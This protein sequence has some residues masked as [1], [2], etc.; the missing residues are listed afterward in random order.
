[1]AASMTDDNESVSW[2]LEEVALGKG[3]SFLKATTIYVD[4][5]THEFGIVYFAS[6]A[7]AVME[8]FPETNEPVYFTAKDALAA[9]WHTKCKKISIL[10]QH[11]QINLGFY[12]PAEARGFLDAFEDATAATQNISF[13]TYEHHS[14]IKFREKDFDMVKEKIAGRIVQPWMDAHAPSS[15]WPSLRKTGEW[16]DFT[17]IA[18]DRSFA[19]HRVKLCKESDYFKA[20]C[21]NGFA[22][23]NELSVKLPEQERIVDVLLD[24]M[25]GT[26][27][28]TTGSIFTGFALRSEMEKERVLNDLLDVFITADK[29]SLEKIKTKVAKAIIDRMPFVHDVLVI[30]DLAICIFDEQCP[31][32]DRGLRKAILSQLRDRM[33]LILKDSAAW[34]EYSRSKDVLMAFHSH[35]FD[36]TI[37]DAA[38]RSDHC[39]SPPATLMSGKRRRIS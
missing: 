28:S 38:A 22:E 16:S 4:R 6:N 30:V 35:V 39:L 7:A 37:P 18:G 20:I 5:A 12:S 10:F 3:L 1:M 32:V 31:Q 11:V 25:Y 17:I 15:E 29:Y 34:Q 24:E 21:G 8:Q 26:Y 9:C 27:N 19:V 33:P 13:C 36:Q 2:P 14:G 23:S